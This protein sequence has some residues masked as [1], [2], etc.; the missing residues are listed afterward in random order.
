MENDDLILEDWKMT[1]DGIAH[2]DDVVIRLRLGGIP[3]A[4]AIIGA[5]LASFQYTSE[6]VF[7]IAGFTI[8]ATAIV[9][10]LG[11]FCLLPIFAL[12]MFY[13][14]L[15][16]ISVNH[17]RQI[18]K[19]EKFKGKLQ[20][21]TELTSPPLTWTHTAIAIIVYIAVLVTALAIA[22]AVNISPS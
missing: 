18:E 20:I 8:N 7:S 19:Q 12:D 21:T 17:A 15:L 4:S 2:F 14:N 10:L 16:L 11:A 5:G 3:I 22:Y 6:I 13:Y 9:I 1:K